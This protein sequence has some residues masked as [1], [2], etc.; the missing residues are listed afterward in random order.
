MTKTLVA[1]LGNDLRGDDAA[2]LLAAREIG[3]L[4]LD[5]VDV[6]EHS[7]DVAA[8]ADSMSRHEQVVVIDAVVT[9]APPGT[10]CELDPGVAAT[11]SQSSSHGLGVREALAISRALGATPQVRLIGIEGGQFELGTKPSPAVARGASEAAARIAAQLMEAVSC[12]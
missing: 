8:L 10:L 7:G 6:E 12:A 2:G 9:G 5:N 4:L 1:G 11:R 3:A